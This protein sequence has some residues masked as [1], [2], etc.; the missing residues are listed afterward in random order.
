M[1]QHLCPASHLLSERRGYNSDN[2]G[3]TMGHEGLI[4][5]SSG[6]VKQAQRG[7]P[8]QKDIAMSGLAIISQRMPR[9]ATKAGMPQ[10][11][12]MANSR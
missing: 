10:A 7:R 11:N 6:K 5:A 4:G 2:D 12:Q 1:V 8:Y 9:T 3:R